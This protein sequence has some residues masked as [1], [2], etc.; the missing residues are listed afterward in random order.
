LTEFLV[1][2]R[3]LIREAATALDWMQAGHVLLGQASQLLTERGLRIGKLPPACEAE[4]GQAPDCGRVQELALRGEQALGPCGAAV[5]VREPARLRWPPEAPAGP[6]THDVPHAL[7]PGRRLGKY[8]L[9]EE[10]GRGGSGVVFRAYHEGL[11]TSVAIKVLCWDRDAASHGDVAQLRREARLLARLK[12]PHVVRVLDFEDD[13][14]HPY[15]VMEQV[16]GFSLGELLRHWGRLHWD[17]ATRIVL[18]VADALRAALRLG[19]IHRDVKADNILLGRDGQAKLADLGLAVVR[20]SPVLDASPAEADLLVGTIP[21]MA[22]EQAE[23]HPRTD[24]RS[25]I[26]SLGVTLYYAVTGQLPFQ[27]QTPAEVLRKHAREVPVPPHRL[28]PE[29]PLKLSQ[30]LAR[31]LA[32]RPEDR[33]QHYGALIEELA[34]VLGDGG[35][36]GQPAG[37]PG[38]GCLGLPPRACRLTW[39]WQGWQRLVAT[40]AGP[41]T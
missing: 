10:V 15:L 1:E 12:H 22:P 36:Q 8:L 27:G 4:D 7:S 25:D 35:S 32:K 21:Y 30:I 41:R 20:R 11:Q 6:G 28:V 26:Y 24:H 23:K 19:I 9:L 29:V 40:W 2:Q 37:E 14:E 18:Q 31:M 16:E 5:T 38:S 3:I 34:L 33:F 39:L 17:R 13:G